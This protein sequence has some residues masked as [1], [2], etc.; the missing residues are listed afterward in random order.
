M[1]VTALTCWRKLQAAG[2]DI[3]VRELAVDAGPAATAAERAAAAGCLPGQIV[4]AVLWVVR[5][6]PLLVLCPG[7]RRVVAE[8]LGAGAAP[9]RPD[10]VL[11]ATGYAMGGVPPLGHLRPLPTVVDD[12]VERFATVWCTAGVPGALFEVGVADLLAV[13]PAAELRP[14]AEPA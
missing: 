5:A 14:V 3:E 4:D 8:R 1:H 13:L 10:Q 11:G 2:L 7:D 9:A 6:K 12:S